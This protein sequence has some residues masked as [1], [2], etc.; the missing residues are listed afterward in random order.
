M[1]IKFFNADG[2]ALEPSV[3]LALDPPTQG[4]VDEIS[5]DKDKYYDNGEDS[6]APNNRLPP[7]G[8]LLSPNGHPPRSNWS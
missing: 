1:E 8:L 4:L 6:A 2:I 7:S 3:H 5:E